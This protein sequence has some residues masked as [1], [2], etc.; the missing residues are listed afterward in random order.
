[1]QPLS[2]MSHPPDQ[3]RMEAILIGLDLIGFKDQASSIQ[4]KWNALVKATGVKP[5][6]MYR[7]ACPM[8]LLENAA[9]QALEGNKRIGCRI[10][11]KGTTSFIHDLLNKAW[12]KFWAA[13]TDY[14]GWERK[15]IDGLR[16]HFMCT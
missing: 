1:V 16:K 11:Q 7:R 5:T 9:I 15:E 10:A 4:Q 2:F 14:H 8:E 6:P 3:A 13:P 12:E